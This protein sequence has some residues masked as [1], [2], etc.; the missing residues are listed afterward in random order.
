MVLWA[1]NSIIRVLR[2]V[3]YITAA[4]MAKLFVRVWFFML[5]AALFMM[6]TSMAARPLSLPTTAPAKENSLKML[7]TIYREENSTIQTLDE[8]KGIRD[9]IVC[10]DGGDMNEEECLN[11]RTLSA[12]TDYIYTQEDNGP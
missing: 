6:V 8:D 5:C 3:F 4:K 2:A 11:R 9:D 12:H 7:E 10:Q 1:F